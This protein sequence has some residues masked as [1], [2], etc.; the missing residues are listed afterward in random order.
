MDPLVL[1]ALAATGAWLLN[2]QQQRRRIALL[3]QHLAPYQIERLLET[4]T[5]GYLRAMGEPGDE[6]RAQVLANLVASE[7]QLCGQ[8]E[9][10]V[11][12]FARVPAE[13]ARVSR[14]PIG[15]PL[16]LQV[17]PGASFDLRDLLSVHARGIARAVRN[18]DSLPPR[19]RAFTMTAELLL[20]QHSCHW[21]CKSRAVASARMLARHQ[22][23]HAQLLASV[24]PTTRAEYL[25]LTG[26]R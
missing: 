6:R 16:L 17:L 22:T 14:L 13:Q 3:S 9:R 2:G 19:E 1:V 24:S 12:A 4:L 21:Y 5:Q 26:L 8:F 11:A 7:E 18:D 20:M 23:P 15:L 25:A 10:F